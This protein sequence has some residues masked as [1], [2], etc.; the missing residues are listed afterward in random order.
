MVRRKPSRSRAWCSIISVASGPART[1]SRFGSIQQLI[2]AISGAEDQKA[3]LSVSA[4]REGCAERVSSEDDG[5]CAVL[6][7]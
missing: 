5:G 3:I 6:L 4:E 1:S 7:E 2:D